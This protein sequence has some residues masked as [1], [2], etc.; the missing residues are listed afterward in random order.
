[1]T[2]TKTR[3]EVRIAYVENMKNAFFAGLFV[4]A[5]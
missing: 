2:M 3:I 4:E 5:G 1:M